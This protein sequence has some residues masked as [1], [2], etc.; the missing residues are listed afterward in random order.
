MRSGAGRSWLAAPMKHCCSVDWTLGSSSLPAPLP[1]AQALFYWWLQ[2]A[3]GIGTAALVSTFVFPITA[4]SKV[5]VGAAGLISP[6]PFR[7]GLPPPS[8]AGRPPPPTEGPAM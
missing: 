8:Q 4:G 5:R 7:N 2:I 3:L 6:Q 1:T